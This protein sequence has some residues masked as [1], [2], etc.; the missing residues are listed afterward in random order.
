MFALGI[1]HAAGWYVT[2]TKTHTALTLP[3]SCNQTGR[4]GGFSCASLSQ[5][6]MCVPPP[7][8]A[9]LSW[10]NSL[11]TCTASKITEL[12]CLESKRVFPWGV[13]G[14]HWFT[15]SAKSPTSWKLML[16]Q[17]RRSRDRKFFKVL[18][19]WKLT[20]YEITIWGEQHTVFSHMKLISYHIKYSV[21]PTKLH[22][23][24]L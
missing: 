13:F 17:E 8:P 10:H 11:W 22:F 3:V 14:L 20:Y 23:W 9:Q 4:A 24:P 5:L 12:T 16:A 21:S 7:A 2:L 18:S 1:W 15:V 6:L 19:S